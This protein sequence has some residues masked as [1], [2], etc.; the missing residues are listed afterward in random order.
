[1]FDASFVSIE[2]K[3]KNILLAELDVKERSEKDSTQV[4]ATVELQSSLS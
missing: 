4:I 3:F 1:M 2:L